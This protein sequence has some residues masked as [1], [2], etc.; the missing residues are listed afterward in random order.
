MAEYVE[1]KELRET[2]EKWRDDLA[3]SGNEYGCGLMED[4]LFELDAQSTVA[5]EPVVHGRW[6]KWHGDSRHYCSACGAYANVQR[7]ATGYIEYEFLD[8]YC[9][10]CGAR[11][12][13]DE[14]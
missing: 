4:V 7:D 2:Y 8:S 1:R 9:S 6:A 10:D 11:M 12:D 3:R 5:I 13:G 14:E